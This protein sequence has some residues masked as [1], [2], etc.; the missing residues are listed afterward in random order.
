M[1]CGPYW[2]AWRA[3]RFDRPYGALGG[4]GPISFLAI[5]AYARRYGFEG[6]DFEM[7]AILIGAMDAEYLKWVGEK[8][9]QE[10]EQRGDPNAH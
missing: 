4:E 6:R 8:A 3:L 2:R 1:G 7:L 5:D 9:K 10:Q